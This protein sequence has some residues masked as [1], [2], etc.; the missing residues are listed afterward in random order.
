MFL[1]SSPLIFLYAPEG[2]T[3]RTINSLQYF[4][5]SLFM[6]SLGRWP[7]AIAQTATAVESLLRENLS[8]ENDFLTLIDKAQKNYRNS[9]AL[10]GAAHRLRIKRNNYLHI[11]ISS[12]DVE[13]AVP[14][15]IDSLARSEKCSLDTK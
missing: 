14:F 11:E 2:T 3:L 6:I 7:A 1:Y 5:S 9:E 12:G 15:A 4:D 13:T 8:Y 10:T